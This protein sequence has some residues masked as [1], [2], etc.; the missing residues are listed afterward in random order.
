MV[1]LDLK[2]HQFYI[3]GKSKYDQVMEFTVTAYF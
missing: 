3:K 2:K 1:I